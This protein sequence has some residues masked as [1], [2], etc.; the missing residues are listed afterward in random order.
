[1]PRRHIMIMALAVRLIF[2]L[3]DGV[4]LGVSSIIVPHPL[5]PSGLRDFYLLIVFHEIIYGG[6]GFINSSRSL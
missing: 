6:Q 5:K 3:L 4:F 1:M 2:L